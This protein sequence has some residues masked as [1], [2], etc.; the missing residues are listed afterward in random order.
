MAWMAASA[1]S[2]IP[3]HALERPGDAG[4]I[5][6]TLHVSILAARDGV[7]LHR[8]RCCCPR[9][10]FEARAVT[11]APLLVIV[12][13]GAFRRRTPA[14]GGLA[15]P[16]FAYFALPDTEEE[17]A[18]PGDGG[19]V[20]TSITVSDQLL[21]DITGGDDR[22][23]DRPVPIDRQAYRALRALVAVAGRDDAW[24]ERAIGLFAGLLEADRPSVAVGFEA[25][26]PPSHRR[27][28]DAAREALLRNPTLSLPDLARL[29]GSSPHHLSRVFHRET[30]MTISGYRLSIRVREALAR[31]S[32]GEDNL[33]RLACELGFADHSHL[34]RMLVREIG[35]TPTAI[36]A[37]I[38]SLDPSLRTLL[39]SS[40]IVHHESCE[41][42]H[43]QSRGFDLREP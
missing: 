6:P 35:E 41:V 29:V 31:V 38:A 4:Y 17:F 33:A 28:V 26:R 11:P 14:G 40:D 3:L 5:E 42:P 23:R 18:H 15:D 30:G 16:G 32:A 39:S 9:S 27:I 2:V 21:A 25:S 20:T 7:R 36:R 34:T 43:A 24:V 13:E 19:D 1:E 22:L 37:R 8:V 10:G 12:E